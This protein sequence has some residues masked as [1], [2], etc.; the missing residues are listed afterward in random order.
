MTN[1]HSSGFNPAALKALC[2]AFDVA[3]EE[4]KH[5]STDSNREQTRDAIGKAIVGLAKTGYRDPQH[6]ARY[7]AYQGK[8]FIDLRGR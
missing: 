6:L 5:H 2:S 7:G 8:L 1:G 3:W 4:V